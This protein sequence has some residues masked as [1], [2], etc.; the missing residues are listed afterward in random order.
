MNE[1][2]RQ[3]GASERRGWTPQPKAGQVPTGDNPQPKPPAGGF[4]TPP[5]TSR[6]QPPSPPASDSDS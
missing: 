1:R 3:T 6:D 5:T 4:N 2:N